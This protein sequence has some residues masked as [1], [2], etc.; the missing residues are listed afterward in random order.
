MLTMFDAA[1]SE[2]SSLGASAPPAGETD[3]NRAPG[4]GGGSRS[5]SWKVSLPV[6]A[7]VGIPLLLGAQKPKLL[8]LGAKRPV[9]GTH[10]YDLSTRPGPDS[11]WRALGTITVDLLIIQRGRVAVIRRVSTSAINHRGVVDTTFALARTLAPL[12]G[13]THKPT[14]IISYDFQH[15]TVSGVITDSGATRAIHDVLPGPAFN[16]TDID[17]IVRSLP[18]APGYQ[19]R[20]PIYDPELGGY[21]FASVHVDS[22]PHLGSSSSSSTKTWLVR[23]TDGSLHIAYCVDRATRGLLST[24]IVDVQRRSEHRIVLRRTPEIAG[25]PGA[26]TGCADS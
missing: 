5:P 24:T 22:Y 15:D 20:L 10:V 17:V 26:S 11:A 25:T 2:T 21:C 19:A 14:G 7:L 16:S 4:Y 3:S 1:H 18:L 9:S 13:R 6:V 12:G 8:P 23:V